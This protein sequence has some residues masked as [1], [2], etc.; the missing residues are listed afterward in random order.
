MPISWLWPIGRLCNFWSCQCPIRWL[1]PFCWLYLIISYAPL[2]GYN[3]SANFAPFFGHAILIGYAPFV[4]CLPVVYAHFWL[5]PI[6]WL[7]PIGWLCQVCVLCPFYWYA[8]FDGYAQ[9]CW[10]CPLLT[11]YKLM[12]THHYMVYYCCWL[13]LHCLVDYTLFV[14]WTCSIWWLCPIC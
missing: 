11:V 3:F 10:L 7:C 5:C 2:I 13:C 4:S 8:L 6:C 9:Y 1:T 12:A 14:G